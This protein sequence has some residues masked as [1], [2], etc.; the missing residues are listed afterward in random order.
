M[1]KSIGDLYEAMYAQLATSDRIFEFWIAVT[2]AVLAAAFI[3]GP[4]LTKFLCWLITVMYSVV[5][6]NLILRASVA[7]QKFGELQRQLIDAGEWMPGGFE[8]IAVGLLTLST[9][10]GGTFVTLYFV[11]YTYLKERKNK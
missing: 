7:S 11:W 6:L 4:R 3:A 8:T 5:A 10:L 2:F 1:D 9:Y